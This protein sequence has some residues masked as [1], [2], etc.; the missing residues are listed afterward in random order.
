MSALGCAFRYAG[1]QGKQTRFCAN[2]V[3]ANNAGAIHVLALSCTGIL[4][5]GSEGEAGLDV[6]AAMRLELIL[7]QKCVGGLVAVASIIALFLFSTR[8]SDDEG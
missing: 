7:A 6:R 5:T 4:L 3:I 1:E 8:E 2:R